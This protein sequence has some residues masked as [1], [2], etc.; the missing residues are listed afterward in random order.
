MR[1]DNPLTDAFDSLGLSYSLDARFREADPL[2]LAAF[3]EGPQGLEND[4][5]GDVR[6]NTVLVIEIGMVG[7]KC[8]EGAL[9]APSNVG[10]LAVRALS[11][12]VG[13]IS[14]V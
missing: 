9:E 7:F 14:G 3:D 1:C 4:F 11:V 8:F 6:I 13:W 2:E 5:D 12:T 10:R